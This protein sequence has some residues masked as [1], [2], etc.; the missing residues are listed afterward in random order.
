M[1]KL[2][3]FVLIAVLLAAPLPFVISAI[4]SPYIS[5]P[6]SFG[7]FVFVESKPQKAKTD[8]PFAIQVRI[9]QPFIKEEAYS[10][11]IF[12]IYAKNFEIIL[13]D[14]TKVKDEYKIEYSD[15]SDEKYLPEYGGGIRETYRFVYVGEGDSCENIS[16]QVSCSDESKGRAGSSSS[17]DVYYKVKG[18]KIRFER[19]IL[20]RVLN[21][22]WISDEGRKIY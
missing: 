14:G 21:I 1:K 9:L 20:E 5:V 13:P 4:M 6:P 12:K 22:P 3:V 8:E 2:L 11:G 7:E 10:K 17:R 19:N 16:F 15:F 18:N